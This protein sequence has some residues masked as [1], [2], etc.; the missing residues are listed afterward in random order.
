[1]IQKEYKNFLTKIIVNNTNEIF[2]NI[3]NEY[4]RY[5][6]NRMLEHSEYARI[7]CKN[8]LDLVEIEYLMKTTVKIKILTETNIKISNENVEIKIIDEPLDFYFQ[9]LDNNK[10]R[11]EYGDDFKSISNFNDKENTQILIKKFDD[12]YNSLC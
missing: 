1:M 6:I 2:T 8:I 5:V 7:Y 3:S 11:L 12:K 9:V 4:A 10:Y